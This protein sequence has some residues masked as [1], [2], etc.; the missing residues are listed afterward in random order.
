VGDGLKVTNCHAVG[1]DAANDGFLNCVG[2][3]I[4]WCSNG[5]SSR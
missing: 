2:D 1:A 5:T 4:V 3:I